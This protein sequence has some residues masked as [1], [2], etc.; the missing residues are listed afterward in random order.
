MKEYD[1]F[2][3]IKMNRLSKLLH[4]ANFLARQKNMVSYSSRYIVTKQEI[5]DKR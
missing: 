2:Y 4:K 3:M 1:L 5:A